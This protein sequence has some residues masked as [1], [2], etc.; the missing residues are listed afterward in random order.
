MVLAAMQYQ[1]FV[2]GSRM[3]LCRSICH[4]LQQPEASFLRACLF[5]HSV[6]QLADRHRIQHRS[7][8][9][10]KGSSLGRP[11]V[12]I[13]EQ[14]QNAHVD[15]KVLFHPNLTECMQNVYMYTGS[16]GSTSQRLLAIVKVLHAMLNYFDYDQ[17]HM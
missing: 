2:I 12:P 5:D 17:P 14:S 6:N 1:F 16:P 7:W 3:T 9:N 11:Q 13:D 15:L 8:Q 4:L 10:Y